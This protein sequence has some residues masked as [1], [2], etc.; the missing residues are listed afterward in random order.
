M[1]VVAKM[2]RGKLRT[3][4]GGS[5]LGIGHNAAYTT[6]EELE[7][8]MRV[9]EQSGPMARGAGAGAASAF[10]GRG[11]PDSAI[12][13]MR[14]LPN[15]GAAGSV[16][17]SYGTRIDKNNAGRQQGHSIRG[18]GIASLSDKLRRLELKKTGGYR[19]IRV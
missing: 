17:A 3:T 6:E 16:A 8:S 10:R 5:L 1:S 9:N 14:G 15:N 19:D 18:D 7:D 11:V 2:H 13:P 12:Y 4:R